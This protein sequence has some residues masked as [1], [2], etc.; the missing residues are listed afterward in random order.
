VKRST[1]L[2]YRVRGPCAPRA[3]MERLP[4]ILSGSG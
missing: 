3:R 1:D 2:H 4:R